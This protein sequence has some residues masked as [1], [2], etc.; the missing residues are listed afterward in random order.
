MVAASS[1]PIPANGQ[2]SSQETKRLVFC[3]EVVS[4]ATSSG[5]KVRRS[6]TSASM[7]SAAKAS[8][9]SRA[10]P[11]MIEKAVMVTSAPAR[12]TLALPIG[13]TK[14]GS[15]GT[16]KVCPYITSFSRKTIGLGSRMAAFSKPLASAADHG[17]DLQAG[18]WANQLAKHCECWAATRAAAPL[19]PRKTIGVDL[20]AG[21]IERLGRR[22]DDLVHRLHG[23]VEGHE[24]D[25]RLADRQRR[26]QRPNRRS[27]FR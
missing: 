8:A 20:S 9:A 6:M 18:E 25:N 7:P 15:V 27:R 17:D 10:R 16:S 19:G 4:V 24:L 2:P 13:S 26:R 23:E 22:V 12:T 5:R 21:H 14:S 3:T 11:T 1:A